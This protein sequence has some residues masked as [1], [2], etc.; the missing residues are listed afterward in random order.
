[1]ILGKNI[2]EK[3]VVIGLVA[4]TAAAILLTASLNNSALNSN[5]NQAIAQQQQQQQQQQQLQ[6][7]NTIRVE[8]GGGNSTAPL[9]VYVPQHIEIKA[10]QTINWYNPTPVGEP[11]SVTFLQDGRLFPPFAAPFAVPNSTEFK[12]LIPSP[13][14]EPLIVP[15]PPGTET[16]TT[17]K[18]VIIDNAR[19]YIP[20]VIDSTGKNVTYLS[21]N[22]NYTMDGTESYVNS[23]WLWPQG[24]VPPGAPPITT[25]TVTFEKPG[26]YDY[27]CTVHPWMTGSVVVK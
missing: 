14:V 6:T 11:H 4:I 2:S 27:L 21:L 13:N 17:T 7:N 8:A 16:T 1:M 19:A 18:T 15:N 25:F 22:A 5:S 12:A 3:S 26:I 9:T 10:G 20:T 24:Q 23:G